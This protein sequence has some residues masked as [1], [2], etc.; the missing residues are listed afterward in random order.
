[1]MKAYLLV[2]IGVGV[3]SSAAADVVPLAELEKRALE[4]HVSLLAA[5]AQERAAQAGVREAWSNYMPHVGVQI[6]AN[7]QPGRN[8]YR[9]RPVD[10]VDDDDDIF[11][12]GA[13]AFGKNVKAE[14]RRRAVRPVFRTTALL[15]LTAT[16][17]DFGRTAAGVAVSRARL[18]A[19]KAENDVTRAEVVAVVRG[20]YL[21]WLSAVEL[22]R[23]AADASADGRQRSERVSALISEGA[24]PRGD[25][26]PVEADRLLSQ[27]ELE[28]AIADMEQARMALEY[29]VG[30][31]LAEQAEPDL[32]LLETQATID[33]TRPDPHLRLLVFQRSVFEA[34]ARLQRKAGMPALSAGVGGGFGLQPNPSL[35]FLPTYQVGVGLSIPIWDGGGSDASA[36]ATEARVDELRLRLEDAEAER[37]KEHAKAAL[38]AEHAL[39][40]QVTAQQLIEVCKS[41][42]TDTETGYEMGAMQ[43]DQVQQARSMLRRAETELVM[44]KVSH[45]EALLRTAP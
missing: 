22:H 26:A 28:R 2:L 29:A 19:T 45:T 35:K 42:V 36:D 5:E 24:R 31:S 11:V 40:R 14:V 44:A 23:I 7:A 1:M 37:N 34:T 27:L 25:L 17:Y 30:E 15:Q 8:L 12:Q 32:K 9:V 4:R 3:A 18:E 16:L 41:R 33:S 10:G 13:N 39:K 21:T 6:D 43:F 38:D 20:A